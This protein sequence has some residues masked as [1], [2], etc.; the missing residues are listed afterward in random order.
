MADAKDKG[1]QAGG[2]AAKA[3]EEQGT[4]GTAR[5]P[6]LATGDPGGTPDAPGKAGAKA[7]AKATVWVVVNTDQ[8]GAIPRGDEVSKELLGI[9]DAA[10]QRLVDLGVV[11]RGKAAE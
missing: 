2:E 10:W 11:E 1:N 7:S 5:D 3:A 6:R 8:I 9:D 4:A